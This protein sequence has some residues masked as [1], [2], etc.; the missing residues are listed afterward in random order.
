MNRKLSLVSWIVCCGVTVSSAATVWIDTDPSIGSPVREVDD[1]YALVL[2]MHSPELRIAGISTTYGNASL[3]RT[4]KVARM[5]ASSFGQPRETVPAVQPGA[6][7]ARSLGQ[8][9]PATDAL[10]AVLKRPRHLTYVALGPLT[11]LASFLTIHPDLASKIDRVVFVGGQTQSIPIAFGPRRSFRIHDANIFK[12][13]AAIEIVMRAGL[14]MLS[15]PIET[16]SGLKIEVCDLERL[17]ED[18]GVGE[19]L[20]RESR[21]WLWFW[22]R[23]VG[24]KGGPIFDALAIA[25]VLRPDLLMTEARFAS[26]GTKHTLLVRRERTAGAHRVQFCTGFEPAIKP[27]VMRRLLGVQQSEATKQEL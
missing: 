16:A 24:E 25:A 2:A 13:P 26:A 3:A 12:D 18:G 21:V 17:R 11:N 23:L 7:S 15:I 8:R 5:L 6:S 27:M 9:S 19:Y 4:T 10:A 20:A 22:T 1:A 14:P